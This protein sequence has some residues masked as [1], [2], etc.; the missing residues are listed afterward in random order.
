MQKLNEAKSYLFSLGAES[1][2]LSF[3]SKFLNFQRNLVE[4]YRILLDKNMSKYREGHIAVVNRLLDNLANI[5][6][7]T[8]DIDSGGIDVFRFY[9]F[10]L[11]TLRSLILEKYTPLYS[12]EYPLTLAETQLR[13]AIS[14]LSYSEVSLNLHRTLK[15]LLWN[16]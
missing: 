5:L 11:T 13:S 8:C 15:P 4:L 6:N 10:S 12:P 2:A 16:H 7:T 1:S 9:N 3:Q 14:G